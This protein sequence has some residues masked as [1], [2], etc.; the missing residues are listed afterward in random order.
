[1]EV[2]KNSESCKNFTLS[3]SVAQALEGNIRGVWSHNKRRGPSMGTPSIILNIMTLIQHC[4]IRESIRTFVLNTKFN[5]EIT[6]SSSVDDVTKYGNQ[7]LSE[8][9]DYVV[10]YVSHTKFRL[11]DIIC[12]ILVRNGNHIQGTFIREHSFFTER[13]STVEGFQQAFRKVFENAW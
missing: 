6:W 7:T 4:I 11:N 5:F 1:M 12:S 9:I 8:S 2:N 3:R 13:A 10:K